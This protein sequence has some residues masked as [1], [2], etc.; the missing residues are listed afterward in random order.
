MSKVRV[1]VGKIESWIASFFAW[2]FF[3]RR[4]LFRWSKAQIGEDSGP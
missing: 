3:E 2:N 4:Q 1:A